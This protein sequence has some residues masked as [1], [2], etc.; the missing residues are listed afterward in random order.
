MKWDSRQSVKEVARYV[1]F[2]IGATHLLTGVRRW[3]VLVTASLDGATPVERFRKVYRLG[4][5]AHSDD[6][7]ASSGRGTVRHITCRHAKQL[8]MLQFLVVTY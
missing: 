3:R 7:R 6:Q 4:T 2:K 8:P 5:W 1:S